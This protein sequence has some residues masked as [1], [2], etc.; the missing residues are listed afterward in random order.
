MRRRRRIFFGSPPTATGTPAIA[1]GDAR[2]RLGSPSALIPIG[3]ALVSG[4]TA[5]P[6]Q[7]GLPVVLGPLPLLRRLPPGGGGT[8]GG[9]LRFHS[10]LAGFLPRELLRAVE[11]AAPALCPS[12]VVGSRIMAPVP[13]PKLIARNVA[14]V[15]R[16]ADALSLAQTTA[17]NPVSTRLEP[18]SAIV[19][20]G[21]E[22]DLRNLER[23][24]FPFLEVDIGDDQITLA[25]VD[26]DG[27]HARRPRANR[28]SQRSQPI[29]RWRTSWRPGVRSLSRAFPAPS[30]S[31]VRPI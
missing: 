31:S 13:S 28:R 6:R 25:D 22:C 27:W 5:R 11:R 4:R 10:R 18:E 24:F 14:A 15:R 17:G 3:G 9:E 26:T 21:L 23:R 8:N 29:R 30:A 16:F 1:I 20:P 2:Y 7:G 19:F 12:I